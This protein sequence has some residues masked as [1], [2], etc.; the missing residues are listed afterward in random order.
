MAQFETKQNIRISFFFFKKKK[1]SKTEEGKKIQHP[2]IN[3]NCEKQMRV[4][5]FLGV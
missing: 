2:R 1:N 3:C 5:G 4:C